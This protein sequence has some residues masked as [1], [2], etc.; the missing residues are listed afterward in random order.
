MK[1]W[2][3]RI[4]VSLVVLALLVSLALYWLLN[5]NSGLHFVVN[6]VPQ[7]VQVDEL[8]GTLGQFSVENLAIDFATG[9]VKIRRAALQWDIWSLLERRLQIDSMLVEN[10]ELS[11]QASAP[12]PRYQPWQGIVLPLDISI[13]NATVRQFKA[14]NPGQPKALF[15]FDRAQ[16]DANYRNKLLTIGSLTL[17]GFA[18][19]KNSQ[20]AL[21]G[22][23]DLSAQSNGIVDIQHQLD[24]PL[25]DQ[26]ISTNGAIDG[27]WRE[28]TIT[29]TLSAPWQAKLDVTVTDA[30][31]QQLTWD[32][33]L[34]T[35]RLDQQ[36]ILGEDVSLGAGA[37]QISGQ[38]RPNDGLAGLRASL[39]GDLSGGNPRVS[40]WRIEAD[41]QYAD[42]SLQVNRLSV[43]ELPNEVNDT[44]PDKAQLVSLSAVGTVEQL[45]RFLTISTADAETA[46]D[47]GGQSGT[48]ELQGSWTS[49]R[50]P[51]T[52][53]DTQFMADGSFT[54][55]GSS[56]SFAVTA[57]ADGVAKSAARDKALQAELAATVEAESIV[58]EKLQI[59][60]GQSTLV[61]N[62]KIASQMQ[63][64]WNLKSPNLGDLIPAARGELYSQGSLSG[65]R[66]RPNIIAQ[67][68]SA[69][70]Q[71]LG[72]SV[73][74]LSVS[75]D[76]N[77][78]GT[79][80]SV[81]AT[82]MG[83]AVRFNQALLA[84]QLNA[85][86]NGNEQAHRLQLDADL[87]R[88][89][90]LALVAT[91]ALQG[92]SW[93]GVLSE[94]SLVD[95]VLDTWALTQPVKL[96]FGQQKVQIAQACLANQQQ[97][98]CGELNQS[99][100]GVMANGEVSQLNLS[101]LNRF[102]EV[103]DLSASGVANG[104]FDYRWSDPETVAQ[105]SATL[106]SRDGVISW[107]S[108]NDDILET[109]E[110]VIRSFELNLEQ[111]DRLVVDGVLDLGEADQAW[112]QMDVDAPFGSAEFEQAGLQGQA[113]LRISDLSVLPPSILNDINLNGRLAAQLDLSGTVQQP[114]LS[115]TADVSDSVAKIPELGLTLESINLAARSNGSP[116]VE[117]TGSLQSGAGSM[118]LDGALDLTDLKQV[119]IDLSVA[120]D[121]LQLANT[122]DL[123][124]VGDLDFT[125]RITPKLIDVN[126]RI[127]IDRAELD[128]KL[129]DSAL[130]ESS[131]VVLEG[132]AVQ[133]N[134]M[135]QRLD[136]LIELGENTHIQA[137]G[138]DAKLFG[139]LRVTQVPNGII[140]GEGQIQ[141]Q[142]GRYTAYGQDLKLDKGRLIFNGG[143]IDDPT[144]DL[145]AQKTVDATTAG[146]AVSGRASAPRLSLYSTPSMPDQDILSVLVFD[147]PISELGSQDGLTLLRIASSLRGDGQ[148]TIGK[149]TEKIQETLGLTE[150]ELQLAGEAPSIQAGKQLSSKFYVGY[151]YGL[152]DATQSLILKY[153]LSE[154]WSIKADVGADSGADLRYQVER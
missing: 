117:L 77:L 4:G 19:Q 120:G 106:K 12:N 102:I 151:G 135:K 17:E 18:E 14:S 72:L 39:N 94:L 103:Y 1:A 63:L 47:N 154:A 141:L 147:K 67:V 78:A 110:L 71:A 33:S 37:L 131:D 118:K 9:E 129:P 123:M 31:A 61:A 85:S 76:A 83:K 95:P 153:K 21:Q 112:W 10:V 130:L 70:L 108:I 32:G 136:L 128:F 65:A 49:L 66:D 89:A 152:L 149:T 148:S 139:R 41:T 7:I 116:L 5:T 11:L 22:R 51:L 25:G 75:V 88:G 142:D 60:S 113:K 29:Q 34:T 100:L 109:E 45:Q 93:S 125:T 86:I 105:I 137:Q 43:T 134:A 6:N 107:Q 119:T 140:R 16:L 2:I 92:T 35:E 146:V 36:T 13:A 28:L 62:G 44:L 15:A 133:P 122:T 56:E 126:G 84:T 64:T 96:E 54:I 82:L 48:V 8:E 59:N 40:Y 144:L 68:Q 97:R 138:L 57:K 42:D 38:F 81:D 121:D 150:L 55:A 124:V 52:Q 101:N 91:G 73:D 90:S 69:G 24:W 3:K 111:A 114:E 80:Q 143:S 53:A 46:N 26:T 58:L 30:L 127:N 27:V 74:A 50:W 98:L 87:D 99:S 23:V 104:Q 132:T 79:E 20:L 115:M 145:R